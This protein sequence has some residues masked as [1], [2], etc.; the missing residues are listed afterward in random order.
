MGEPAADSFRNLLDAD[1][2][3]VGDVSGHLRDAATNGAQPGDGTPPT[4]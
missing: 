4:P 1:I 3:R 2:R